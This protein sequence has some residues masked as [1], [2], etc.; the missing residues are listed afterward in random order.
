[1][2]EDAG[3]FIETE[4]KYEAGADFAL[5]DLAGLDGVAAITGPRT[6]RLRAVYFDTR[7]Y[8]LAEAR[9]TLRRR[10]GGTDAGW[11]LKL[12]AGTDSRREVHA[13]LGRGAYAV[14]ARLAELVVGWSNRQPLVPIALL[15]TTR[16]L[17]RLAAPDGQELAEIADDL[18]SGSLPG[19]TPGGPAGPGGDTG[20]S[21]PGMP[22]WREVSRWRE[23]EVELVSGSRELLGSV[24]DLLI[25]AGAVPSAAAS[26]LSRLLASAPG[27]RLRE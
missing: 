10:T 23:V 22:E 24:G 16:R 9:I 19:P 21:G 5:P 20:L 4:R 6:Y 14:P 15:A 18:V 8:G 13:P 3:E 25:R 2:A 27:G 26:K 17:R 1:M 12:P 11:H 7:D